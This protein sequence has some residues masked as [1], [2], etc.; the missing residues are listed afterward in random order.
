MFDDD[1]FTEKIEESKEESDI[2]SFFVPPSIIDENE[3]PVFL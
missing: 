1:N 3:M 2:K